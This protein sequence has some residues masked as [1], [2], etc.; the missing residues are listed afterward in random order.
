MLIWFGNIR[1]YSTKVKRGQQ[2]KAKSKNKFLLP[3]SILKKC[4]RSY[5]FT[6]IERLNLHT[7]NIEI[8]SETSE[9]IPEPFVRPIELL[10]QR[11]VRFRE[12]SSEIFRKN[13]SRLRIL[14]KA[15][16]FAPAVLFPVLWSKV[17]NKLLFDQGT[18]PKS[19]PSC[20]SLVPFVTNTNTT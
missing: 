18:C 2:M 10:A 19:P 3:C 4:H 11:V 13:I 12:S 14:M 16:F 8:L 20:S 1:W 15:F 9:A 6:T 7:E 5:D 17:H